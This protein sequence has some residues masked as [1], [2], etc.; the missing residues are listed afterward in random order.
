LGQVATAQN[1]SVHAYSSSESFTY[2]HNILLDLALGVGLPIAGLLLLVSSIWLWGR[3]HRIKQLASWYCVALILPVAV[4]SM[5]EFPFAYAYFLVPAMLA[6][7]MLDGLLSPGPMV[8][9]GVKPMAGILLIATALVMWSTIEYFAIEEDFRVVRFEAL[10]VGK[11]PDSY[12]SPNVLLLTQLGALLKGG[13]IVPKPGMLEEELELAREVA[14]RYP[15]P[16][17]QNRYALSLALNGQPN[18]AIRQLRVM[19]VL[20]G[21]KSYGP[22]KQY[23]LNLAHETY[24]QLGELNLP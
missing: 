4:H 14:L 5:L 10:R 9:I 22:I 1:A 12:T 7:G 11:T 23:W 17:T 6:V 24:P 16:A 18:E 21:E 3:I 20:H 13:R 19:R 8:Q 15:W 2:S